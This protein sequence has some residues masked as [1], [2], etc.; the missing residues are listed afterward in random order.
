MAADNNGDGGQ[1]R[2]RTMTAADDDGSR[3]QAADYDGEG[4]ERA[5]RDGGDGRVAM[6]TAA[7][8]AS[9][10]DSGGR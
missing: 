8:M 4:Q 10:E 1:Q 3:D 2:W 7:K 6:M 5:A 9:A